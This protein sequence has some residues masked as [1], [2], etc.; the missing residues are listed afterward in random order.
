MAIRM[1]DPQTRIPMHPSNSAASAGYAPTLAGRS[2]VHFH[3]LNELPCMVTGVWR[4]FGVHLFEGHCSLDDM[5]RMEAQGDAWL[6]RHPGRLVE[7]VVIYP[8]D[9]GMTLEERSR[10]QRIIKRWEGH[11]DA[12]A[13][14][15]LADGLLG[16]LQRSILT[17]MLMIVPPPHPSKI[18]GQTDRAVEYLA[19]Y[20]QALGAPELRPAELVAGVQELATAFLARPR[21]G[22]R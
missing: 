2:Y 13:T 21:A 22:V 18:F 6:R 16:S 4:R 5:A 14:V 3:R 17:G 10:M 19:P 11:R 20:V 9:A 1:A 12:S 8:S 15:I 7:L